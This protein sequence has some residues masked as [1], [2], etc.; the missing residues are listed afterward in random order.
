VTESPWAIKLVL[1]LF[2]AHN[3]A[4]KRNAIGS[5]IQYWSITKETSQMKRIA[6]CTTAFLV[7]LS[8]TTLA[9]VV[10]GEKI[11]PKHKTS[12]AKTFDDS[13][14]VTIVLRGLMVFHP[15]PAR[16][17]FE[18]GILPAPGHRFRVEVREKT[19][20]G[21]STYSVP[22]PPIT[23]LVNDSWSLEFMSP[24]KQGISFYQGG[25]FDRKAGVGDAR[26]FRWAVDIEGT[27]F[28]NQQVMIKENQLGPILRMTS[29]EFY[30]RAKSRPTMR[31][32]GDG[33]YQYFGSVAEE[34]AAD[35]HIV[36]GDV[37][38]RSAKSGKEIL[39][40][41]RRPGT[42]YEI[43][44]ENQPETVGHMASMA[45]S[46]DHFQY[47]YQVIAKPK[48]EWFEFKLAGDSNQFSHVSSP[49]GTPTIPC[50]PTGLGK[51]KQ[52]LNYAHAPCTYEP[53][54]PDPALCGLVGLFKRLVGLR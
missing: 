20:A 1:H 6:A 22:L 19:D 25:A 51:R 45:S 30:T 8:C 43:I 2:E 10:N 27:E 48:T 3:T 4:I 37:V 5:H 44:L 35:F 42:T 9:P 28:Y 23:D 12:V 21:V 46:S 11:P 17:Y 54:A 39:R 40:L 38:L 53:P 14:T 47:Y 26:D 50:Q 34:I 29:G 16:E 41:A 31:R 36:R 33:T 24:T 7:F 49:P 18:A 15:D 52:S 32:Q 13:P